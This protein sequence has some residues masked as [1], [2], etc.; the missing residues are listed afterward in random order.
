MWP[1][2]EG[3]LLGDRGSGGRV[4]GAGGP[5]RLPPSPTTKDNGTESLG[6]AL[7]PSRP[8]ASAVMGTF[9]RSLMQFLVLV[10]RDLVLVIPH[11][12]APGHP[13]A[14]PATAG[15]HRRRS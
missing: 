11:P 15:E 9:V 6:P 8:G 2:G 13:Q 10:R 7:L 1:V 12:L 4:T 5:L 14:W 3:S